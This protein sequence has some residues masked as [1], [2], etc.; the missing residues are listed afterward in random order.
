MDTED[1]SPFAQLCPTLC[2]P[3]DCSLP[4][5]SLHGILQARVLEWV[6]VS[7]SKGSSRPRDQTWA[8]RI[9]GRCFN[10]WATK[11]AHYF[12]C[13]QVYSY[14]KLQHLMYKNEIPLL[15]VQVL[16]KLGGDSISRWE[17]KAGHLTQN[18]FLITPSKDK[19]GK[20]HRNR[21]HSASVACSRP[22]QP[23]I[24]VQ[25]EECPLGGHS[26]WRRACSSLFH[27][28]FNCSIPVSQTMVSRVSGHVSLR[29]TVYS[30]SFWEIHYA[31]E[32]TKVSESKS[33]S[34][35]T[36]WSLFNV[37]L[38]NLFGHKT[39]SPEYPTISDF[40]GPA[41]TLR[42]SGF[43]SCL[44]S[45]FQGNTNNWALK[46]SVPLGKQNA[47]SFGS[48]CFLICW[49]CSAAAKS[50]QSCPT[51]CDAIDGSPPGSSVHAIFQARVLEW[52][53]QC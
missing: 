6:A 28:H 45:C 1:L 37:W 18:H 33:C 39:P 10:L 50:L 11:E 40:I 41:H 15:K 26:K 49:S 9:V 12:L 17:E 24:K 47:E 5:S 8:S 3:M 35:D 43:I 51:L 52:V 44:P 23:F 2:D 36:G 22:A 48:F 32:C 31:H 34:K 29:T 13:M 38:P 4:G 20:Y 42:I 16:E 53:R 46:S 14:L 25:A 30:I 19:T 21:W 27:V 7:F